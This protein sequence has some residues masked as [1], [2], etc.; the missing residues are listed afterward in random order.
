MNSLN[1]AQYLKIL[2]NQLNRLNFISE[3]KFDSIVESLKD[4]DVIG[5]DIDFTLL[6]YDKTNMTKLMYE[7]IS[8]YLINHKNYP[9]RIKY[10]Y[11]KDFVQF[12]SKKGFIIDFKYGNCLQVIKDKSIIKCYHGKKEYTQNEI[13]RMYENGKYYL[14]KKSNSIIN[15]SFYMITDNF[16][17]QNLALFMLC[18]DLF[19]KNE[20]KNI[21]CYK[22]IIIHMM[23]GMNYSF[24][25]K[26]FE[27]FSTFGYI[28]PEIHKHHDF[29]L[30]KNN[31]KELLIQL[32]QK[33]KYLFFATN[34]NYSYSNFILEKEIGNDYD[35]YFD[36]CFYKSSKPG[37]F[38][39]ENIVNSKCYFLDESEFSC[40]ELTD[41]IYHRISNGDKKL[42]RGSYILVEK[43]FEKLLNKKDIKY[44]FIGDNILSDCQ[45]PSK[46]ERWCSIFIFD[47]INLKYSGEFD[48]EEKNSSDI[49]TPYFEDED[50]KL[51]LPNIN[52]L[53]YLIN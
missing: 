40:T 15:E 36:L 11:N 41:E 21:N 52:G 33:R 39:K 42:S 8:K 49:L 25:I 44:L 30:V 16:H 1:K 51:A 34:S 4:I 50:C 37:F 31:I 3:D 46:I 2:K 20:L 26:P 13:N 6:N 22:D 18:V 12:F 29:Y 7:S 24:S 28:F 32:K 38:Q 10:Q 14:F 9:K 19:D 17:S 48:K 47:D 53:T 35:K 43:Y 23:E 27:D 5:F 45:A